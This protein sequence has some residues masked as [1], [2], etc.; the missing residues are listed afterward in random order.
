MGIFI[1]KQIVYDD[2]CRSLYSVL[3]IGVSIGGLGSYGSWIYL[4]YFLKG[5]IRLTIVEATEL[6][7][8]DFGVLSKGKSDPYCKI[9]GKSCL[10]C[11]KKKL[12][13]KFI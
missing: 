8:A 7:K 4:I 10:I 3:C 6:I 1:Q 5:I 12:E 2:L 9:Y 13:I 11:A